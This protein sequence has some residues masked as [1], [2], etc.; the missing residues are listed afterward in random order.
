RDKGDTTMPDDPRKFTEYENGAEAWP[1]A[2]PVAGTVPVFHFGHNARVNDYGVSVLRNV[3]SLQDALNKTLTDEVIAAEFT[4]VSQK[5]LLGVAL[6][7]NDAEANERL[8]KFQAGVMNI[9]TVDS[10][11]GKTPSV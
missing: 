5:L 10:V 3:L 8:Q 1:L 11:D 7:P 4:A 9:L 2:N 6:D